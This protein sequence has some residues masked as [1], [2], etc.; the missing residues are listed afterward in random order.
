MFMAEL[1]NLLLTAGHDLEAVQ[2][3]VRVDVARDDE[4]YVRING[5]EETLKA[6]DMIIADEQGVLSSVIYGPDRR[7]QITPQTRRVLFTTYAPSGVGRDVVGKH[8]EGIREN[9]LL[10][11]PGAQVVQL[12]VYP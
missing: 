2:M 6:G 3:P 5:H 10:I 1:D 4:R 7:T 9:V 8:L 12:R 11:A